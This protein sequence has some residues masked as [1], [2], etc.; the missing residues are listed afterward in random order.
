MWTEAESCLQELDLSSSL[1]QVLTAEMVLRM[2]VLTQS[3]QS[4]GLLP[5]EDAAVSHLRGA[6]SQAADK[7]YVERNSIPYP[8]GGPA[9]YILGPERDIAGQWTWIDVRTKMP[10][11]PQWAETC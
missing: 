9:P 3:L 7:A 5:D 6:I 8:A 2:D 11:P 10:I 4:R 1:L